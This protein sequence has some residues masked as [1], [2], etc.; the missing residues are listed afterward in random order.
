MPD[1]Q[2]GAGEDWINDHMIKSSEATAKRLL[3][4]PQPS[5]DANAPILTLRGVKA[6]CVAGG[7]SNFWIIGSPAAEPVLEGDFPL[8]GMSPSAYFVKV[9]RFNDLP[10]AVARGA[11]SA[12]NH[13]VTGD[14]SKL[15]A[16]MKEVYGPAE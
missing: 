16:D 7:A 1:K 9:A 14:L 15:E 6:R 5:A 11:L 3:S 2:A 12:G 4:A 10:Y 13:A 8:I